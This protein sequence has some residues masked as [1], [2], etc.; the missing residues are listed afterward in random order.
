MIHNDAP[1]IE[2][3]GAAAQGEAVRPLAAA[4]PVRIQQ[5]TR[6]VVSREAGDGSAV[7]AL[8]LLHD[9]GHSGPLLWGRCHAAGVA[10]VFGAA[11]GARKLI[12]P[13]EELVLEP[14]QQLLQELVARIRVRVRVRAR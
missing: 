12:D 3:E 13:L 10:G 8:V 6:V 5:N 11:A 4:T 7:L 9:T 14:V 2:A 1:G